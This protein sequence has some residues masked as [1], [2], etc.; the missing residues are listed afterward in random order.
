MEH[1]DPS[2][3]TRRELNLALHLITGATKGLAYCRANATTPDEHAAIEQR[4]AHLY[5]E[6]QAVDYALTHTTR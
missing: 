3:L 5:A 2:N 4:A 1:L 6:A